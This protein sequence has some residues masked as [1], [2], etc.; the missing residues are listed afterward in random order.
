[1]RA[2]FQIFQP[3]DTV[4]WFA[5]RGVQLK[6][7]PDGRMFPVTDSAQTIVDCFLE[8]ARRR[9]IR[10][11]T[12]SRV[13]RVARCE[14]GGFEVTLATGETL[15]CERVLLALGGCR[16]REIAEIIGGLGH[17]VEP[18]VPSLFT[19]QIG[20][21]WVRGLAGVS[22]PSVE[23]SVAEDRLRE[24]GPLLFTHWGLSGP[25]ILRLSAWGARKLHGRD[26]RFDLRVNWFPDR[27]AEAIA[28]E[29]DARRQ[30]QGSR[31]IGQSPLSPLPTRLW[32]ELA[33]GA[34]VAGEKPWSGLTRGE[35]H[36][37][38][39]QLERTILPVT[40]KSLNKDEFVT[41]G[42]VRLGEVDFKT[43]ESRVCPGV[44]FAGEILDIDGITG[45]YNFQAAWTT[46]WLAGR[47]L[48]REG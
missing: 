47:G 31:R 27:S 43:M 33:R 10:A 26:Y 9:G 14:A 2:P 18:P 24:R 41:C 22:V 37:L 46:G 23:V 40:G 7:E 16:G 42:G 8:Q 39:Q 21:S 3:R 32:E 1:M 29:L 11:R 25:A 34:G 19:F 20:S 17:R 30:S 36:Q 44:F 38:T 13:E 5:A 28:A 15:Q 4:A 35:R 6:T 48:A 12:H 45:G